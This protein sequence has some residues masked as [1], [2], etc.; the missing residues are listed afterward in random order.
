MAEKKINTLQELYVEEGL[1]EGL[2]VEGYMALIQ[3]HILS[4]AVQFQAKL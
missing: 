3:A 4:L 2:E 1:Q